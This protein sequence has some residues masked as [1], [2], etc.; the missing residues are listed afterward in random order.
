[1]G[2]SRMREREWGEDMDGE[3]DRAKCVQDLT[4]N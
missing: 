3:A 1:M 2:Q 4:G